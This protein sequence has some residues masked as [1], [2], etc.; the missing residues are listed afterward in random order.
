MVPWNYGL[1]HYTGT[2]NPIDEEDVFDPYE[3]ARIKGEP[4]KLNSLHLL[5]S[6]IE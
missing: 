1:P 6:M 5:P 4:N 2:V 3:K